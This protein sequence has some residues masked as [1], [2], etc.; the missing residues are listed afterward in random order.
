MER[1]RGSSRMR[2]YLRHQA[3]FVA[4]AREKRRHHHQRRYHRR[5]QLSLPGRSAPCRLRATE[6]AERPAGR[7]ATARPDPP[8]KLPRA[9]AR[10]PASRGWR[11]D[12]AAGDSAG[13][14]HGHGHLRAAA[15]GGNADAGS[16]GGATTWGSPWRHTGNGPTT[17]TSVTYD[18]Y[19]RAMQMIEP[20]RNALGWLNN[21]GARASRRAQLRVPP[22]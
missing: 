15:S 12:H 17:P 9:C 5:C 18:L 10:A 1:R 2:P 13:A 6:P 16:R 8:A 22:A 4:E 7:S 11:D 3:G 20:E 14:R 21:F 19:L